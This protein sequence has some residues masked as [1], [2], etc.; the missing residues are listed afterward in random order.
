VPV[1][2][3]ILAEAGFN[4]ADEHVL[5]QIL[6]HGS[7]SIGLD[8]RVD[9]REPGKEVFRAFRSDR[10]FRLTI[11]GR[12]Y[13]WGA[14]EVSEEELREIGRVPDNKILILERKDEPDLDLDSGDIVNLGHK[15][16]EKLHTRKGLVTVY[17][18]GEE[19]Q[20]PPGTYGTEEL[21]Q[22]LGVEPGYILNVVNAQGQ[23]DPLKPGQKTKI[24]KGMKFV[25]QVP[26]GGSS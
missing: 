8:E 9:L 14:G 15:G 16:T 26:C 6:D 4:P 12:G 7:Q 10:V 5:V 24:R 11:D 19:K 1:G 18:D 20:I 13:E 17:L 22:V 2:G 25:S 21:M 3:Q 23:L